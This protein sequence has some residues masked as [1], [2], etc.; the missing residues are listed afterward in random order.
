[1]TIKVVKANGDI[2]PFSSRSIEKSIIRAG[3]TRKLARTIAKKV[4]EKTK[5]KT[6]T[7]DILQK[8]LQ[9]LQNNPEI[10][11]RY[12]LKRAIM[13]LGP[14]GY[15]FE[16]YI[17]KILEQYGYKTK[18][19]IHLQGKMIRQEIDI[20]ATKKEKTSMIEAK[21]HNKPGIHTNTKVAMYTYARFLDIN[22][23]KKTADE[24]W[25]VTNTKCTHTAQKYSK[26]VGQKILSWDQ[27]KKRSLR[28]IIEQKK[29][30]P[31]TIFTCIQEKTKQK[32]LEKGIILA[33]ELEKETEKTLQ[34]KTGL[35]KK[36]I[37]TLLQQK[38][39]I[40]K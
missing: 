35:N 31:I 3:A 14:D 40:C 24:P 2:V 16:Q 19:G 17:T 21:Y 18:T 39:K 23:K 7:K 5:E 34:E 1:M 32:L 6:K 11:A 29:L 12:D 27:P 22:S 33:Q 28:T 4:K 26:G 8:A 38:N 15:T 25:L 20:L 36:E 37:Q 9:L 10:A 13:N 30:Y